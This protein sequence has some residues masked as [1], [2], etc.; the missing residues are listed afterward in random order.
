MEYHCQTVGGSEI[1][2]IQKILIPVFLSLSFFLK[3]QLPIE[4]VELF[5]IT[6]K[7]DTIDFIKLNADTTQTKPTILFC[8]GS[9]PMPLIVTIDDQG[10]V[11]LAVN[12]F[13]YK[14]L[15]EKYNIVLISMPHTPVVADRSRLN[16]QCAY[17]PDTLK[18]NEYDIQYWTDNYLDKYV[19]RGNAV[20]DFLRKQIW[21]DKNK[22]ILLGHS[23]GTYVAASLAAQNPDIYALGYFS[24]SIVGRYAQFIL[25]IRNAARAGKISKEEAQTKIEEE[26]DWWK[27]VCRNTTDF[28]VKEADS[29]RTWKSFSA[30]VIAQITTLKTPVFIAYGTEDDGP[31]MCDILPVYFELAGKTN[32]KMRPF[33]GCG[34]N[35]EEITPD[36]NHNWDEMHWNDAVNEFILW[37]E[38]LNESE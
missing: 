8:Q 11:I 22:I 14:T 20:L 17:M 36:G 24:G 4:D 32:Y 7:S 21:V 9:L 29:K 15:L 27:N 19:E 16:E 10:P 33:I 5:S 2:M 38:S 1:N 12:N 23:Q 31:Q 25:Q 3:A 18:P 13:E 30:P 28:S 26:Y 35:F 6:T 37:I 34:H